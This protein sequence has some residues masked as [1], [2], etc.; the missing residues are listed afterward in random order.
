MTFSVAITL[1][2]IPRG[3][4]RPRFSRAGAFVRTYTDAK[5]QSYEGALRMAASVAMEG[6]P[7]AAGPL[8]LM[9][10]ATFPVPASWSKRKR[11]AALDGLVHPTG[12]PDCDNI[13]KSID[14]LNGI[15]W[16]DDSQIVSATIKKVY[17]ESAG[18]SILVVGL[19]GGE[20]GVD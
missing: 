10:V 12:R 16:R 6:R 4:G 17:G 18:L 11:Q 2:G 1:P 13:A 3:K 20:H 7:P 8:D 15:V 9:M 5:T 14:S 19:N